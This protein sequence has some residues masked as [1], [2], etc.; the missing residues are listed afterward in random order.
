MIFFKE[1]QGKKHGIDHGA[2]KRSY[3]RA[4]NA[5]KWEDYI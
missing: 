4:K 3:A 2:S 5:V 1:W